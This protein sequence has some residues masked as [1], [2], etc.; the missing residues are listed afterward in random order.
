MSKI[1]KKL[2][3]MSAGEVSFRLKKKVSQELD[4]LRYQ[5]IGY[6][7]FGKQFDADTAENI[8]FFCLANPCEQVI[9]KY[10]NLF[11]GSVEKAI[12]AADALLEHKFHFLGKDV[13]L[14]D[15]IQW[16]SDPQSGYTYPRDFYTKLEIFESE[17][18]GADIKYVWELNRHQ[19]FIEVAKAY[20]LTGD[21]KYVEKIFSWLKSWD[22]QNP[23]KTGV[24]WTSA[25]E[26]AVRIYSW[27]WAFFFTR[28]SKIWSGRNIRFFYGKLYEQAKFTEENLSFYFSPYNHL[29]G[30]LAA[31]NFAGTVFP[32]LKGA[33]R[34]RNHFW[35]LL[36]KELPRQFH[37][38]GLSVE[39]ATY[40]H[41]FTLGFY[42][43]NAILR[44]INGFPVSDTVW[45]F[46][47]RGLE[48]AMYM[49][50]PD[51][52]LPMIGDIDSA[53]SV[54]FYRPEKMWDLR[55]FQAVGAALFK[56]RDMKAIAH[57][58]SEEA[59]WLLGN[60][61]YEKFQHLMAAAPNFT[62][63]DFPNSGYWIMRD[64]W[65]EY[66]SCVIIDCGEIADGLFE[67]ETSSVAHGH[68]DMLSF[69]LCLNGKSVLG[70]PGFNTYN[71]PLDWHRYFRSTPGHNCVTVNGAEQGIHEG[72]MA[73]SGISRPQVKEWISCDGFDFFDGSIN[74]FA[75]P[76][77]DTRHRRRLFLLKHKLVLVIDDVRSKQTGGDKLVESFL[78]FSHEKVR[79]EKEKGRFI[80]Q[81]SDD[82][83]HQVL[84]TATRAI[85][86]DL[87]C[88]DENSG[89]EAGW[90][91]P[92]Y[93]R[94]A[95]GAV[96]RISTRVELPI[97]LVLAFLPYEDTDFKL[98]C[99]DN[100]ISIKG[101]DMRYLFIHSD[102]G[103]VQIDDP[104][105]LSI[106]AEWVIISEV[107][108]V[109][110]DCFALHAKSASINDERL[111]TGES[112]V[113][114]LLIKNV[115][116]IPEVTFRKSKSEQG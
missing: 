23:Y 20:F 71:G 73:W 18:L 6:P 97:Q 19:F 57:G 15:P 105:K 51:G 27:S 101:D 2:Q 42:L 3:K 94:K 92:G 28:R 111:F 75:A 5:I 41:H 89:P 82:T 80:I 88:G 36:E 106:D 1:L 54:Y 7:D 17:K 24:N 9:E 10:N 87:T 16:N 77:D 8:K 35:N 12:S 21:E 43:Q 103:L 4:Y 29:I 46:L 84:A 96:G 78:H 13:E 64:G 99:N 113:P 32:E 102:K 70:D 68:G 81:H 37:S 55:G 56:R 63:R 60:G 67:D 53:R 34:W 31:L 14:A 72:R 76:E 116:G 108:G 98:L 44:K 107:S 79:L 104:V 25:L 93:G 45:R 59:F 91:C 95:P 22:E 112:T 58:F 62:S 114:Y 40:Y 47:E 39:Q 86:M 115:N 65:D 110:R 74:H 33:N 85:S 52:T 49:T 38:D 90:V 109:W 69:D 100:R 30:E 61:A 66:A 83:A 11:P 26:T 50:K 48:I